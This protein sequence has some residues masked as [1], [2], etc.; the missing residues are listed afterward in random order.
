MGSEIFL[1][2]LSD[3]SDLRDVARSENPRGGLVVMWWA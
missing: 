2:E 1:S 3:L